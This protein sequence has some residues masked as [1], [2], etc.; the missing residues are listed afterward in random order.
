MKQWAFESLQQGGR[1]IDEYAT[2]FLE[3]SQ[4]ALTAIAT[5]AMKVKGF[6]KILD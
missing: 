1:T 3:L 4:C 5:E 2:E 6:L